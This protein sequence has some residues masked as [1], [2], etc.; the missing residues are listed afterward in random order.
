MNV[1][2][3]HPEAPTT[4]D[5]ATFR[6]DRDRVKII[7]LGLVVAMSILVV[8]HFPGRQDPVATQSARRTIDPNTAPW[9]EMTTLPR[10][11][12]ALAESMVQHRESAYRDRLLALHARV[13]TQMHDLL[14]VRGIGPKTLQRIAPHLELPSE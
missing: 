11:G 8:P 10:V 4:N 13:F 1:S 14:A 9:W 3:R 7:C 2:I 5:A 12:P 6:A